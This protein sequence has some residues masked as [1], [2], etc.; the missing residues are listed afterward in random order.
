MLCEGHLW[1]VPI[2]TIERAVQNMKAVTKAVARR[3][4]TYWKKVADDVDNWSRVV[5]PFM[6]FFA[7]IVR[8]CCALNRW[9][10][11]CTSP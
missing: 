11:G 6:Y 7:L 5:V 4:N 1:D 9:P 3:N 8:L 2:L 10:P